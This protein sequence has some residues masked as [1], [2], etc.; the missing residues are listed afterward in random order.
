MHVDVGAAVDRPGAGATRP[1]GSFNAGGQI[2]DHVPVRERDP[3][4]TK[5]EVGIEI[6]SCQRQQGFAGEEA[7]G[8]APGQPRDLRRPT[9]Y[10]VEAGWGW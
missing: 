1:G 4:V 7:N 5:M 6:E 9:G 2:A 10:S 3:A 8:I